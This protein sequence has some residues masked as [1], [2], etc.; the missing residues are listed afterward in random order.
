MLVFYPIFSN[1][2]SSYGM[3]AAQ[4]TLSFITQDAKGCYTNYLRPAS[5]L[6][7]IWEPLSPLATMH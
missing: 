6:H 4:H 1:T 5:N 7:Y 3:A 2:Q